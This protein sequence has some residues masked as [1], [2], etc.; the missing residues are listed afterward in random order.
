MQPHHL[1][2]GL[3][4]R[5]QSRVGITVDKIRRLILFVDADIELGVIRKSQD[6]KCFGTQV[7]GFLLY[8]LFHELIFCGIGVVITF[9]ARVC[10]LSICF[11]AELLLCQEDVTSLSVLKDHAGDF[12]SIDKL[13]DE[14]RDFVITL[15]VFHFFQQ[16]WD[17]FF[18]EWDVM[19]CPAAAS[20][21]FPHD[22]VGDR[23]ERTIEVNGK[24]GPTT[25][26]LFWAGYSCG[27]YLPST[28]APIGLT[29]QG[30]P[31][32]VQI[33]TRQ[34]GDYTSLRFAELLEKEYASFV[35]PPGY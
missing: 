25:D 29:P 9:N 7:R 17:R 32:G 5:S 14:H 8:F 21:A 11:D 4:A 19:I 16:L 13:F 15:Q 20:A 6:L 10:V 26:Q 1:G 12:L 30:L 22:H 3:V 18:D 23:H 24:R 34:Y 28:V 27:F 33:I 2:H 35:P 31:S